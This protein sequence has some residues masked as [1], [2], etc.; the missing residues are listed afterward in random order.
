MPTSRTHSH[1][2][3][4]PV[5]RFRLLIGRSRIHHF[6]VF[7]REAIPPRKVV[8]EYT[9]D[10]INYEEARR[11]YVRAGRPDRII[12]ARLNRYWII[13]GTN[14]NGAQFINHSCEPNLYPQRRDGHL[15]L[16]SQRRIRKGDELTFDYNLHRRVGKTPCHCGASKCRGEMNRPPGMVQRRKPRRS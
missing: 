7:A 15:F 1:R 11:R 14:G 5:S 13:D 4:P 3:D 12:L 6:G 10:R 9:G 8:I 16:C 2:I